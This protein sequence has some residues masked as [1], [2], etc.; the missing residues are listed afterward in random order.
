MKKL[1]K[2]SIYSIIGGVILT[3]ITFLEG[4]PIG[5]GPIGFPFPLAQ[6]TVQPAFTGYTYDY[7]GLIL[8]ILIWSI[9]S[10]V[11]LFV[12]FRKKK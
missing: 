10:F 12:L 8:D 5:G 1:E 4:H 9:I 2:I 7:I 3:L 11:V 6:L